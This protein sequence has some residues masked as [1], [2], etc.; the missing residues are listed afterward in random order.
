[1]ASDRDLN[2]AALF[3]TM[4]LLYH[5]LDP[6]NFPIPSHVPPAPALPQ[7]KQNLGERGDKKKG[8]I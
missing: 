4:C 6:I 5:F 2:R 3:F 1:M 7:I 8:K